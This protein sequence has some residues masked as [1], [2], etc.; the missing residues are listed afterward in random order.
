M[1]SLLIQPKLWDSFNVNKFAISLFHFLK[2]IDMGHCLGGCLGQV[3]GHCL[4]WWG[5]VICHFH[6]F[7]LKFHFVWGYII[8][9]TEVTHKRKSPL[10]PSDKL[11]PTTN[12]L[13]KA[14]NKNLSVTI[15]FI[16]LVPTYCKP[17]VTLLPSY[18]G[19]TNLSSNFL[20]LCTKSC[21]VTTGIF[22]IILPSSLSGVKAFKEAV[23]ATR[24]FSS[25]RVN[26]HPRPRGAFP[27]L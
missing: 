13:M 24:M 26:M 4:Y 21:G 9:M 25:F 11:L 1:I 14:S 2:F 23:T 10:W 8:S 19:L 12:C 20:N 22:V 5:K 15:P 17:V 6:P 7:Y 16:E 27:W 3:K 18:G